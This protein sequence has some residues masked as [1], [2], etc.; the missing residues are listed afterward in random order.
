MVAV[1]RKAIL[2]IKYD[3]NEVHRELGKFCKNID[4]IHLP[5]DS[6]KVIRLWTLLK[7]I[8]TIDPY[9][10]NILKSREMHRKI[11]KICSNTKFDIVHF[12]TIG[13]AEYF[14]DVGNAPKI[15]NHHNLESQLMKR[16]STIEK[17]ILKKLYYKMEARKLKRYE[18]THAKR[19]D[20]NFTVSEDD[21]KL[22]QKLIPRC[23]IVVIPNGVDTEYFRRGDSE[24]SPKSLVFIGGM[25]WYPNRDAVLYFSREIWPFLK[26]EVPDISLTVVGA[27]PPKE[28]LE[29][30]EKDSRITV[31]GFVDDVRPYFANAEVYICPM[32]DG[33][34]TRLKILDTL[35]MS[36][37]L[38]S[39]TMGCEGI[40]VTPGR[41]VLI[42]DT[43]SE[44][45]NQIKKVFQD[46]E[47]RKRLGREGRKLVEEKY[48]WEI[49]GKKL[50]GVYAE[51]CP[52]KS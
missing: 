2:P 16:R 40:E 45:V 28:L 8:F 11:R 47:L 7:S 24:P 39:T 38:V 26:R 37:A 34:G 3:M 21:K 33:G 36:T 12:D 22:L 44:F 14:G 52:Q 25:N 1:F 35:S 17:N 31:M 50:R 19:F 43:P 46:P 29:L 10:A 41:N 48:S 9:T 18:R 6:S 27:Q 15:L 13:L 49:I 30:A 23:K 51:L 32:R 4:I 5:I 42:A 20:I